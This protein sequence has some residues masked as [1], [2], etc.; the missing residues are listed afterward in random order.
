MQIW[1]GVILLLGMLTSCGQRKAPNNDPRFD[2]YK[3][4]FQK[5]AEKRGLKIESGRLSLPISFGETG[6]DSDGICTVP[7]MGR[8]AFSA[9]ANK[10]FNK[11]NFD[12]K[13]ILI[14]PDILE[15]DL[16][17]IEAVVF[18]ELAHC[19]L[20]RDHTH[21]RSLMNVSQ[22]RNTDYPQLRSVYLDELFGLNPDFEDTG[23]STSCG[24]PSPEVEL[25]DEIIY[26]AFDRE[27][28]YTIYPQV[29]ESHEVFCVNSFLK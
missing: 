3:I 21:E 24:L 29:R 27:L 7:G 17:Y 19:V 28:N 10:L 18:H 6:D 4:Q 5:E 11:E 8:N 2:I 20:G 1:V 22:D 9:A 26:Q 23:L 14:S 15:K 25:V 12:R 13:F 16:F